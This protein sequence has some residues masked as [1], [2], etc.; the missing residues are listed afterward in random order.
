MMS[1]DVNFKNFE[2]AYASLTKDKDACAESLMKMTSGVNSGLYP[3]DFLMVAALNR[4]SSQLSAVIELL[5]LKN[6]IV[7]AS[8]LRLQLDSCLR[9]HGAWL[10][11]DPHG[12]ARQ[13]LKGVK[14]SKLK[15]ASGEVMHDMY[16]RNSLSKEFPWV[17]SV[18]ESTSGFIHLSE[19]H[20]LSSLRD[21]QVSDLK[22][23]MVVS[24]RQDH[25]SDEKYLELAS[26]FSHVTKV[27]LWLVTGWSETKTI[28]AIEKK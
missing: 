3:L 6:F 8:L 15:S 12:Y 16:L 22:L 19:K 5:R 21:F 23:T 7:A 18:Y 10:V 4:A 25:I 11:S 17:N 1:S 13:I 24:D 20:I 28:K 2:E 14:I 26:A 9:I 27:L